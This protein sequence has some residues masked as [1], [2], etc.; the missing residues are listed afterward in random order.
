M[1]GGKLG[2]SGA[3]VI[4]NEIG[5]SQSSNP[6]SSSRELVSGSRAPAGARN[7]PV[8][9]TGSVAVSMATVASGKPGSFRQGKRTLTGNGASVRGSPTSARPRGRAETSR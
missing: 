2:G 5:G 4:E 1:L 6:V 3:T 9:A 8:G 7:L